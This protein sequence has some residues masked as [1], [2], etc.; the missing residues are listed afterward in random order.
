MCSGLTLLKKIYIYLTALK[1]RVD[2]VYGAYTNNDKEKKH[3]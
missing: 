3:L 2:V 1:L